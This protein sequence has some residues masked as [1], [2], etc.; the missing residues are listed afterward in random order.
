[1][2]KPMTDGGMALDTL[3]GVAN[4]FVR[5]PRGR[6]K[7]VT[8]AGVRGQVLRARR[9]GESEEIIQARIFKGITDPPCADAGRTEE[10]R[11]HFLK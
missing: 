4:R 8:L 3:E 6:T 5:G 1:M 11:R 7:G 2:W 10:I 9:A